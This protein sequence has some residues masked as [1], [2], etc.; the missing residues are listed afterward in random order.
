MLAGLSSSSRTRACAPRDLTGDVRV[1]PDVSAETAG[2][3][4]FG[5]HDKER[6]EAGALGRGTV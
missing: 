2:C 5:R 4:L 1:L 3:R 6:T